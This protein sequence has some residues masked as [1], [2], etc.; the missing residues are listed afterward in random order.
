[1]SLLVVGEVVFVGVVVVLLVLVDVLGNRTV[2]SLLTLAAVAVTV[3]VT[4]PA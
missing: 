3:T 2:I 1:M 4:L